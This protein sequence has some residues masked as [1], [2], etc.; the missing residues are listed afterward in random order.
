MNQTKPEPAADAAPATLASLFPAAF[1]ERLIEPLFAESRRAEFATQ[2]LGAPL[3]FACVRLCRKP[4]VDRDAL[5]ASAAH[6]SIRLRKVRERVIRLVGELAG[7]GVRGVAI[8]GLATA[9]SVYPHPAY[10]ALPDVDFLFHERE[11]PLLARCLADRGFR[12]G[13]AAG[14]TRVWG[15]LAEASFAP[16]FPPDYGF[17]L[18]VH[19]AVDE[20]PASQGLDAE[21]VFARAGE[22]ETE[23]G[24]C[25]VPAREHSFAIAALNTYR[26]FYRP[27]ALKGVF[28]A[29]LIL[30]RFG[31]ALDWG[32]VEAVAQKGRFVNRMVFFRELLA[33]LGAGLAPV[34]ADRRLA[35][36]VRPRLAAIIRNYQT[37]K[38]LVTSDA[39]KV[40]LEIALL[41]SP[42][43]TL[44]LHWRRLRSLV[45]PPMHYLPGVPVVRDMPP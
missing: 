40:V 44:R 23:W 1:V 13:V 26:D 3:A 12:T 32:E 38:R 5:H 28:D 8:K 31:A 41:D 37:L 45:A 42:F 17:F 9:L 19:R 34:F 24:P 20:R 21:R 15:V 6:E 2:L 35:P 4:A 43:A 10:R 29:C 16:I 36:W 18:D 14:T 33:A 25:L 22:I 7:E 30:G 39:D 27:D 11:L